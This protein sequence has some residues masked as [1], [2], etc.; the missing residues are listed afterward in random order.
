MAFPVDI[1][2]IPRH[3]LG[4]GPPHVGPTAAGGDV[5]G[6]QS[7]VGAIS[8]RRPQGLDPLQVHH[9]DGDARHLVSGADL[10]KRQQGTLTSSSRDF[11]PM[12]CFVRTKTPPLASKRP[13]QPNE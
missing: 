9:V 6:V 5:P 7:G 1:P 11:L 2:G 8:A 12:V 4:E 13:K 10:Q 3:P